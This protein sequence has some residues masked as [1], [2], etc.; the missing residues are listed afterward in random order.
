MKII[1]KGP[2]ESVVKKVVCKECGATIEYVPNDVETLWSGKD[3]DGGPDGAT[4]FKCP[5]C[6]KNV[7]L[8][9]W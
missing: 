5:Q 3:Y 2:H 7:I 9:R 1:Y 4:G 6:G 8:T